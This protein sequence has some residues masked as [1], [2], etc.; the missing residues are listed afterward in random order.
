VGNTATVGII[1]RDVRDFDPSRMFIRTT[2]DPG[3]VHIYTDQDPTW[4]GHRYAE[5]PYISETGIYN[6]PEPESFLQVIDQKELDGSFGNM[7]SKTY[8]EQH[9]EIIHHMLEYGGGE[10]RLL[11]GRATQMDDMTKVDLP[12]F[13]AASQM[14]AAEF[15]QIYADLTLANYPV[16]A[17]LMP[18]SFTVPWPIEF[19]MFVDGL[20]QPTS[21]Y[22]TIKRVY[23]PTHVVVKLPEMVWAKG[24]KLPVSVAVAQ[25]PPTALAGV[26]VTVRILDP[27][28]KSIW[29][30]TQPIAVPA[31]PSAKSMEMG[32]FTIPENLE[33]KFFFIVAEAK[34][35]EGR[36]LSRSVYMPRCL[37]MMSDPEFRTKYRHSPQPSI[38]LDHGPWLRPQV[39][40]AGTTL[41]LKV[42]SQ[43]KIS[44]TE[45]VVRVQVRNTGL[46]P[47]F[48]T[49][50]NITGTGRTFY[51]AD[52]DLWL[53]PGESRTIDYNVLWKDPATRAAAQITVDA[54]NAPLHQASIPAVQ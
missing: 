11:A 12:R 27:A 52:N 15:T 7:F 32:E 25:A 47:A 16:T 38:H 6:M 41:E 54:W 46:K 13:S 8:V 45:S 9:P 20:D 33:D 43:K 14:A 1:E 26:N 10:P 51:G 24:E 3:D 22:Y 28:F 35:A 50:I 40:A 37:K 48:E 31:G 49:R 34:A 18:W 29:S 2:P 4:Y 21:S 53:S 36:L 44:D 42:I 23:E 19:F 39:A 30:K 17:G 5:V